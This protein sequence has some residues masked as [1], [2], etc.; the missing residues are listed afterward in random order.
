MRQVINGSIIA[1]GIARSDLRGPVL[2]LIIGGFIGISF[3]LV[4]SIT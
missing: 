2:F 1:A 4:Y 3:A